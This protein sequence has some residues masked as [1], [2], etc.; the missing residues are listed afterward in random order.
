MKTRYV[1]RVKIVAEEV[2][3]AG[4]LVL[5]GWPISSNP[6][7]VSNLASLVQRHLRRPQEEGNAA[8]NGRKAG[9]GLGPRLARKRDICRGRPVMGLQLRGTL[10]P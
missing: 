1:R 7:F 8:R 9:P 4:R 5:L 6:P 10:T 3:R 2:D